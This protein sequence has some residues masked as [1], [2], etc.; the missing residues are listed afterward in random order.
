MM[1]AETRDAI[2]QRLAELEAANSGSLTADA[3]VAD[4][5]KEDSPL[6]AYFNWDVE[7]AA[8]QHWLDQARALITSV[9]VEMKSEGVTVR[10]VCYVRDPRA[11]SD[12]QGYISVERLRAH[13]DLARDALVSEFGR[14]ADMLRRARELAAA[15]DVKE[16]VEALLT[17]VVGLRQRV[18]DPAE[19][20][21]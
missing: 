1:S 7:Q 4:A 6:H 18:M 13:K 8:Y 21:Q 2:R 15:L 17:N 3:V 19:K 20:R 12:Q 9:R 14:V 16:E 5:R 10:S 11:P